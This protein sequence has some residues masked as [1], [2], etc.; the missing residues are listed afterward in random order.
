MALGCQLQCHAGKRGATS[1]EGTHEPIGAPR[2]LE[3]QRE[4]VSNGRR[5]S[6]TLCTV[7]CG[8]GTGRRGG[9]HAHVRPDLLAGGVQPLFVNP[10]S[11]DLPQPRTVQMHPDLLCMGHLGDP[12]DLRL[13]EDHAAQCVLEAD[14]PGGGGVDVEA[15]DD[16]RQDI[17]EREVVFLRVGR[18]ELV[19]RS[20]GEDGDAPRCIR[21]SAA[22][23]VEGQQ[24]GRRTFHLVDMGPIVTEQ[25]VRRLRHVCPNSE[26]CTSVSAP[27][28]IW[29]PEDN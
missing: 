9:Q 16:V 6:V 1:R 23:H 2:P 3:R 13:G 25:R 7:S 24:K 22:V 14:E 26:L 20:L 18:E 17:F 5:R 12:H 10:P 4:A 15:L 11:R 19:C 29:R 27:P 8:P 28:T 21:A